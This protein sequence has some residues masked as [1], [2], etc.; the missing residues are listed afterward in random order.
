ML[1]MLIAIMGDSFANFMEYRFV[2]GIRTKLQILRDQAPTLDLRD[3]QEAKDV[4]M[5]VVQPEESG[6]FDDDN[7]QG[8]I[9]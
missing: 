1:N 2:N 9:N 8:S 6:E 3:K 7:W 5:I 4:F